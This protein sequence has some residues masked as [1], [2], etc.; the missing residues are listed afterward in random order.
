MSTVLVGDDTQF[1]LSERAG[2]A[3]G[4]GLAV[5]LLSPLLLLSKEVGMQYMAVQLGFIGG[6]YFGFG[7]ANGQT[8]PLLVEFL[9][10]GTFMFAS[11][12]A[13]WLDAPIVLVG[14]YVAHAAWDA[15]HHPRAITMPVKTWYPPF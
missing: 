9:V 7:V 3:V 13:L 11:V 4:L 1:H 10:A 14:G 2:A 8:G 12:A 6:V 15:A 5:I